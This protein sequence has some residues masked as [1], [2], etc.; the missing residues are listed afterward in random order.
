MLEKGDSIGMYSILQKSEYC[1]NA[2]AVSKVTLLVLDRTVIF[3]KDHKIDE[4]KEAVNFGN[5]L[6]KENGVP[7]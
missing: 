6:I 2:L 7:I 1:F 3:E 5:E 4:L